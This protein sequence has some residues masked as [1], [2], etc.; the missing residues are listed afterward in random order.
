M[1]AEIIAG[2]HGSSLAR[3]MRPGIQVWTSASAHSNI[4]AEGQEKPPWPG[5]LLAP[6]PSPPWGF[7]FG[8]LPC[9]GK[10]NFTGPRIIPNVM[11]GPEL[12]IPQE[13]SLCWEKASSEPSDLR[14][15]TNPCSPSLLQAADTGCRASQGSARDF[16][17]AW[18]VA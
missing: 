3:R 17:G 6:F 1:G 2:S 7:H 18:L 9:L 13:G 8:A 15:L 12:L 11:E 14:V 16:W 5:S 4:W 10:R